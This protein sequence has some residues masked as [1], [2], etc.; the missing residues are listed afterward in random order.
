MYLTEIRS[1]SKNTTYR[2]IL[3]RE[4]Y[5]QGGKVKNRT[6]ANLSHGTPGEIEAIRLALAHKGDLSVLGSL[7]EAVEVREGLSIG[8]AWLVYQAARRLGIER[9]LG[10]QRAGKMA[11]WQVMARVIDQGSRLSAVRLAQT[12]A[13][14]DI[15][16]L[17]R[18]FDENDLYENLGWLAGQ[19]RAIEK[20]LFA[21][22]GQKPMI[23]F[24]D[25]T[26]S[27]LE[28]ECNELATWGYNRDEKAGKQ[29]IVIGLLCDEG[30]EP[31]ATEVFQGNTLDFATLGLQ[32]K[33]IADVFGCQ[34]VTLVG[35]RGMIKGGQIEELVQA[36]FHY[37]TALTKGQIR[38]MLTQGVLHLEAF[39]EP[40]REVTQ[41]GIRYVL[42]RNPQRTA[43]L[44]TTRRAKRERL[45]GELTQQNRYLA[46]HPGAR[47]DTALRAVQNR[48]ARLRLEKWLKVRVEGRQLQL[49]QDPAALAAESRL[50]GC[51]VLKSDLASAMADLHTIHDRYQELAEVERAFRTCKTGHLEVRPVYVRTEEST[52]GHIL[53][54]MLAYLIVRYLRRA[55]AA[56]DLTV[57][58]GVAQLATLCSL[59]VGIRGRSACHRL[60]IPRK[61][62]AQL[63]KAA[64]IRLPKALPSQGARVVTRKQLP[65]HRPKP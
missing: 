12:H 26:S 15:L 3:L 16:G 52:R 17:Q 57:E 7:P 39:G 31:V 5:R 32:V 30:G 10:T 64:G 44:A 38:A 56:L 45:E 50:D 47:V 55:W 48:L 53:V 43:E 13:V 37:I 19:Q 63:L 42:R 8:A 27:Y 51:Y 28:G 1:H 6:P 18:G 59:Q 4:T 20:R 14:C 58:E 29:Q 33:K 24:Y 49:E 41:A 34:Q 65:S 23:F 60:P 11:L 40:L 54:V 22:R 35:D 9:A 21:A 2:C 46:E 36:G 25:V 61:P 62:S